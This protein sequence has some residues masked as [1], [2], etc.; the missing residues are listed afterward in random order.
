[1]KLRD[2]GTRNL[3]MVEGAEQP[4]L[5]HD[6]VHGPFRNDSRFEHFFHG[7]ELVA[8]FLLDFPYFSEASFSDHIMKLKVVLGHC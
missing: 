7:V 4:S 6:T 5:A 8:L 2:E 1:M 3:R